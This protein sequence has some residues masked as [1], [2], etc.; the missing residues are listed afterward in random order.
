MAPSASHFLGTDQ[1]GRDLFSR[2]IFGAR[3]SMY[4]GLGGAFL[5]TAIATFLG[6]S[7]FFH[8]KLDLIVQ[9][10]VD[11]VMCFPAIFMYMSVMCLIGQGMLKVIIVLGLVRGIHQ[12]RV[13]RGAVIAIKENVYIDA[14][15]AV[16]CSVFR[17]LIRHILPNILAPAI[18]VFVVSCGYLILA[19]ATLSFLGFGIPPPIPSWG[20]MLSR[21]GRQFMEIA[22]WMAIWPGLALGLAVYGLNMLG[23]AFRDLL[24]PKLKGGVGRYGSRKA[25]KIRESKNTQ[26]NPN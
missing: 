18:T 21:G 16:G 25:E 6:L 11:A 22:P 10:F 7:A 20:G 5:C 8:G 9:R 26:T 3:I 17:I 15:K 13:M 1:L 19:E 2:I 12:S 23:D 4:V 24:D 14:A